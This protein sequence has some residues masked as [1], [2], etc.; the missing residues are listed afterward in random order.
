M[1]SNYWRDNCS[2][3]SSK[4]P[5]NIGFDSE[6]TV[7]IFDFGLAKELRDSEYYAEGLYRLTGFTGAIRYMAPEVGLRKPYNL[8]A[9]VY[10]WSMLMWYILALEPP[11][12]LY[13]PNMFIDR[14]FRKGYR[15]AT[16]VTWPEK[17]SDLLKECWS[18]NIKD[19]PNFQQIMATI[20]RETQ[21]VDPEMSGILGGESTSS[22]SG[23]R[24]AEES[25]R[26]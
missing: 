20:R 4:K 7:K 3:H 17:I 11:L 13:T 5:D 22:R 10:S 1:G 26:Y 23:D 21:A 25:K 2:F 8:A 19:R 9:D 15:P 12:G 18:A 6:G 16:Q 14:V 24:T